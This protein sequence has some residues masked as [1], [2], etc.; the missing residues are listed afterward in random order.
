M[1]K[2]QI[3]ISATCQTILQARL[4]NSILSSDITASI[5]GLTL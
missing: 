4:L 3:A 5:D 1:I 2:A